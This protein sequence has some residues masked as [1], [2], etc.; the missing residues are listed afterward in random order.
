MGDMNN[1]SDLG[2]SVAEL[3]EMTDRPT[4]HITYFIQG[5]SRQESGEYLGMKHGRLVFKVNVNGRDER[6]T[7][8]KNHAKINGREVVCLDGRGPSISEYNGEIKKWENE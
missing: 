1:N 8:G 6:W 5:S 4:V 7:I 2:G 3:S